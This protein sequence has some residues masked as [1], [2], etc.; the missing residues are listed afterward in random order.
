MVA[1]AAVAVAAAEVGVEDGQRFNFSR[2]AASKEKT[3]K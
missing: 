3:S 1:A 2:A